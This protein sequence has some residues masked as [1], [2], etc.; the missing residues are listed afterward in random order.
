MPYHRYAHLNKTYVNEGDYVHKGQRIGD[1]GNSGNSTTA[2]LHYDIF[3]K[4]PSSYLEFVLGKSKAFVEETYLNPYKYISRKDNIPTAFH[5]LGYDWLS[6]ARYGARAAFH[7]GLDIN[8]PGAGNADLGNPVFSATEGVVRYVYGGSSYNSGWGRLIVIEESD[9]E[10]VRSKRKEYPPTHIILHH[11]AS[12]QTQSFE[13]LN[14]YH[15]EK[16]NFRSTL[17]FYAGYQYVIE[18]NGTITQARADTEEGAHTLGNNKNTIGVC[19]MGNFEEDLPT[20]EQEQSLRSILREKMKRWNIPVENIMFHRDYANTL[21]PGDK[22]TKR[23]VRELVTKADESGE[24]EIPQGDREAYE[25]LLEQSKKREEDLRIEVRTLQ[26]RIV[27]LEKKIRLLETKQEKLP[28]MEPSPQM[29][30]TVA[31]KRTATNPSPTQS[32]P[33]PSKPS[34]DHGNEAKRREE[35]DSDKDVENKEEPSL[36]SRFFRWLLYGEE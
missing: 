28:G 9:D 3:A 33:R 10:S 11:S 13:A 5:H 15:R 16:W 30:Q 18:Q 34:N 12:P 35:Q 25:Q 32:P 31:P 2:H 29:P 26:Q 17:G 7:P 21:C 1:V 23:W 14:A 19:L 20:A 4:K 6:P 8:G 27:E 24:R 22:I 36:L